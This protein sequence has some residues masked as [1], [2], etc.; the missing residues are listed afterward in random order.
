M[1]TAGD[2][3]KRTKNNPCLMIQKLNYP[4]LL[5]GKVYN[6]KLTFCYIWISNST[7]RLLNI[8]KI[9][10]HFSNTRPINPSPTPPSSLSI[11]NSFGRS[12]NTSR[13]QHFY[14]PFFCEFHIIS[15]DNSKVQ[16]NPHWLFVI[17]EITGST[18]FQQASIDCSPFKQQIYQKSELCF[19]FHISGILSIV[20]SAK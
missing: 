18:K 2:P 14:S 17:L 8:Q 19:N 5:S 12:C 9:R 10:L 1:P 20:L 16:R 4:S 3:K 13:I 6:G 7:R 11:F 15:A